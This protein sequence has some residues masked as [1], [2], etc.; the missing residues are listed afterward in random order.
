MGDT[1]RKRSEIPPEA[2]RK[3]PPGQNLTEKWPVLTHGGTPAVDLKKWRF[4]SWGLVEQEKEWSWEEFASLPQIETT[5]DIHCVTTWSRFDN[6]WRG[7]PTRVILEA[8]RPRPE[9]KFV[10]VHCHGGYTTNI[11]LVHFAAEG[12]LFAFT[13]DGKP[14]PA[15]HGGPCRLVL[16]ALYF[17]KSAKWVNG[18]EFMA[19]DRPGFWEQYGYH[20]RG[21]PWSEERYGGR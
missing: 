11:P 3:L 18:V 7:V 20:M 19:A 14:I 16:P 1:F 15:D 6:R 8:A 17:W 10:M 13:H 4:R 2:A 5:N 9:A 12:V 21:D